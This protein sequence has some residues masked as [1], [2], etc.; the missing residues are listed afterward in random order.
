MTK[1]EKIKQEATKWHIIVSVIRIFVQEHCPNC[2][3]IS[4]YYNDC[5]ICEGFIV[6][7]NSHFSKLDCLIK[8]L[9]WL[10]E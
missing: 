2:K 7:K 5:D 9:A 3:S 6:G 8:Y 10:K 1:P 4:P